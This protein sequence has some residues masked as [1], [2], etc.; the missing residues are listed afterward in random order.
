MNRIRKISVKW[1]KHEA[2]KPNTVMMFFLHILALGVFLPSLFDIS[3]VLIAVL[4]YWISGGLGITL[5]YHRLLTHKSF[6]TPQWVRCVLT[7]FACLAWQGSP[8]RWVGTHRFHHKHSDDELDPHSPKHGFT[9]SHITWVLTKSPEGFSGEDYAVDLEKE[10]MMRFF[11]KFWWLPQIVLS[12]LLLFG[13]WI[14]KDITLGF[15]WFIWGV[16]FRTI[17]VYHM[18]WF[19]NSAAHT[20]GSRKFD[21]EDNSRN[22]FW[23]ALISWGEGYHNNHHGQQSSASHGMTRLSFDPTYWT[24]NIMSW[25][26]LASNI[27]RP[28]L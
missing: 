14:V 3:S 1:W 11:D 19:V 10:K 27:K 12:I 13:G 4:L 26:G 20:W 17:M 18:T 21:T 16:A 25:L 5:C 22:L 28:K 24:I 9:W 8:L 6:K 2:D 7:T 23:V 15:S